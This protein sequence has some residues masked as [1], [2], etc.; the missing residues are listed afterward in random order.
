MT[1]FT[2][3]ATADTA[4]AKIS[5]MARV[6]KI[7]LSL[8]LLSPYSV[9][10]AQIEISQSL[11][12]LTEAEKAWLLDDSGLK[13]VT[14]HVA[15]EGFAWSDKANKESYWL[16]NDLKIDHNSLASGWIDF[17]QC[18]YQLDPISKVE[19]AY[20]AQRTRN[21]NVVS[22]Q[23][24]EQAI[25]Q[26]NVVVLSNVSRGAHICIKG[27]SQTLIRVANGFA[28][29]RGP[30][31]RKFFDGYFPMIVEENISLTAPARLTTHTPTHITGLQKPSSQPQTAYQFTYAFEG[32]LK[33]YYE[34]SEP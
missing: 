13:S 19:V 27:Q 29:Q 11:E 22:S 17:S 8:L 2:Y 34:F 9:A 28:V 10:M 23:G 31:M 21:L 16:K 15:S 26:E 4:T 14:A 33:P 12:G 32:Q 3:I 18:H 25:T 5:K 1:L 24:I 30:Y 6:A 7:A 20:N